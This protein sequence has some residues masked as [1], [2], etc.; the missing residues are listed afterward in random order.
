MRSRFTL[1]KIA[2]RRLGRAPRLVARRARGRARAS[3][4]GVEALDAERQPVDAGGARSRRT[5]ARS[6]VPGLASS[7]ISASG[8]SGTRARMPASR[9]RSPRRRNR[10][11]VPPPMKTCRPC[12][13]R[14]TAARTRGRRAARRRTRPRAA[15]PRA[16]CELK[17]QYGHLRRHHG[18]CTYSASGGSAAKRGRARRR[19]RRTS[20]L[21]AHGSSSLRRRRASSARSALPRCETRVLLRER[22]L[23]AG[24]PRRRVEEMRVVAEAAGRRAARRRSCRASA[25]SAMIGSGSSAWRTSTSTQT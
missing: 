11:G 20:R 17:S 19:R 4:R 25:P 1:P 16:S 8:S 24:E 3:L 21:R 2:M 15:S 23:G 13:P 9:R 18:M 5:S 10:L 22:Q 12:G 7:V 6:K 14:S